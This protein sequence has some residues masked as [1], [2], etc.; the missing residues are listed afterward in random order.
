MSHT[1]NC[2]VLHLGNRIIIDV[3]L[4]FE[5]GMIVKEARVECGR[6][7]IDAI[8]KTEEL[9]QFK[10]FFQITDKKMAQLP[11]GVSIEK[12]LRVYNNYQ[13]QIDKRQEWFKTDAGKEYNRLKAKE[14][15]NRNKN[16]ILE[17]RAKR[18]EEDRDTLLTRAKEYYAE[19]SDEIKQ[20]RELKK[21]NADA[22][23]KIFTQ[24]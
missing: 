17:K 1:R 16:K 3:S 14:Y 5:N 10:D 9:K 15:Y 22:Q 24:T 11:D 7:I 12:L 13:K 6:L 19:H 4:Y 18:Y 2:E 23:R 20:K 21:E 8:K